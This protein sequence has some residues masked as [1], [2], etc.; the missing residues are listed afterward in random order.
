MRENGMNSNTIRVPCSRASPQSLANS[1]MSLTGSWRRLEEIAH[2][3]MSRS[4][5]SGAQ[6]TH[7]TRHIRRFALFTLDEPV[8]QELEPRCLMP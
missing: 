6:L 8:D 1:S 2:L 5:G 4:Q 3:D 7:A